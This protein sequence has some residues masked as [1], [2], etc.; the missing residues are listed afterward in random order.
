MCCHYQLA[1]SPAPP[2]PQHDGPG[3]RGHEEPVGEPSVTHV[4]RSGTQG[5]GALAMFALWVALPWLLAALM[6]RRSE[7]R[8]LSTSRRP[9]AIRQIFALALVH[10]HLYEYARE[11][12]KQLRALM[13]ELRGSGSDMTRHVPA[14]GRRDRRGSAL[15]R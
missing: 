13:R 11:T 2:S 8:D 1:R 12:S 10:K 7:D 14:A 4:Q 9:G 3:D 5:V 15:E 6:C